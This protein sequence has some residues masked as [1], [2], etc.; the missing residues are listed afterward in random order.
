MSIRLAPGGLS[1]SIISPEGITLV[2]DDVAAGDGGIVEAVAEYLEKGV[3]KESVGAVQV[4]IDTHD[5]VFVPKEALSDMPA[6][7]LL[8]QGGVYAGTGMDILVTSVVDDLCAIVA[9]DGT[10]IKLLKERYANI[11]FFSPVQENLSLRR[12]LP[13]KKNNGIL[14]NITADNIYAVVYDQSGRLVAAEV[15]PYRSDADVVLVFAALKEVSGKRRPEITIFG[16]AAESKLKLV[17][18]YFRNV[19]CVS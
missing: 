2:G 19:L 4:F 11:N 8:E 6:A 1:F 12:S 14:A 18:K 9:F 13:S 5:A 7:G 17:K 15:Y 16:R 10:A 3:S